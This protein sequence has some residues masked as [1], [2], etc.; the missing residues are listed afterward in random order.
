MCGPGLLIVIEVVRRRC[1][2]RAWR[3]VIGPG[4]IVVGGLA[5]FFH[6]P[7]M[8]DDHTT[9]AAER[10]MIALAEDAPSEAAVEPRPAAPDG[11]TGRPPPGRV[12]AR[13]EL[14]AYL[15]R[16]GSVGVSVLGT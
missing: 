15:R 4:K 3:V 16:M 8:S 14:G 9:T 2:T 12:T 5:G 10:Y 11:A 6:E 1:F 13:L 7:I